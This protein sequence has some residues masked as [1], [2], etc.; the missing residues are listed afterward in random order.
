[1]RRLQTVAHQLLRDGGVDYDI[2]A[3][4]YRSSGVP[5][6]REGRITAAT[7]RLA[8]DRGATLLPALV[9]PNAEQPAAPGRASA[10]RPA[11]VVAVLPDSAEAVRVARTA[12]EHALATHLP[13]ALVVPLLALGDTYDPQEMSSG[14]TRIREDLAAIAGRVQPALH[15]LGVSARVCCSPYRTDTTASSSQ[16]NMAAAVEHAA[17]RLRSPTIVV[18][19]A[20]PALAHLRVPAEIL[21]VV[22]LAVPDMVDIAVAPQQ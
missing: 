9:I 15:L 5:A 1:M 13:L 2:V 21:R 20:F 12:G 18:S 17:R 14:Y 22:E 16:R 10:G 3:M 11:H 7:N 8:R 19:A 6:R 4:P